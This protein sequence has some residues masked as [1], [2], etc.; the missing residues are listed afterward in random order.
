MVA[1]MHSFSGRSGKY[2]IGFMLPGFGNT[3]LNKI[4]VLSALMGLML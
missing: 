2:L 3:I 1:C 4:N